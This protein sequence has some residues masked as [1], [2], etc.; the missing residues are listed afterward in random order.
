MRYFILSGVASTVPSVLNTM[1]ELPSTTTL[2]A[3]ITSKC[4]RFRLSLT[5][6]L[7]RIYHIC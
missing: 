6:V 4:D 5:L 2:E 7:P 1:L 3:Y